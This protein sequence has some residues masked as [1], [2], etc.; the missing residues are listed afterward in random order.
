MFTARY[1]LKAYI[2]FRL[3]RLFRNIAK[4]DYDSPSV[5][6]EELCSHWTDFDEILYLSFSRKSVGKIRVALK[7]DKNNWYLACSKSTL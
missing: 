2:Y 5:R 6:M 3:I 7:S 4:S 1:E